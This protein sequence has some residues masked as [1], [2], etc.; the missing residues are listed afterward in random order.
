MYFGPPGKSES[1]IYPRVIGT[2]R[3]AISPRQVPTLT[4]LPAPLDRQLAEV[5]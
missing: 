1:Q 3:L 5:A 2:R 4:H